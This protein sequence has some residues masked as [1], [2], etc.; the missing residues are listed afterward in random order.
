MQVN[1]PNGKT[2]TLKVGNLVEEKAD[3]IVNAANKY[4]APGGGVC[5]AIYRAGGPKLE[6]MTRTLV[7]A[8]G[9]RPLGSVTVSGAA[10]DLESRFVFHAVSMPYV[11]GKS[12]EKEMLESAYRST[13]YKADDFKCRSV[14][15]P[16][17]A[18]GI[19]H[20]PLEEAAA[21]AVHCVVGFL[22]VASPVHVEEVTFVLFDQKTYD[23]FSVALAQELVDFVVVGSGTAALVTA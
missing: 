1:F 17:L 5:G 11:D 23:A 6:E 13:L 9:E 14:A 18:T 12:W 2:V 20:Y 10:G 8:Y 15:F 21:V 4:L 7:K 16:A 19:Y 22:A 3:A